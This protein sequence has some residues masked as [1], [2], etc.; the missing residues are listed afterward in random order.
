LQEKHRDFEY[1]AVLPTSLYGYARVLQTG[2][3]EPVQIG[4]A[5]VCTISSAFS[6]CRLCSAGDF[7]DFDERVDARSRGDSFPI[8]YGANTWQPTRISPAGWIRLTDR[9]TR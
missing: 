2:G 7:N 6:A 8:V 1:V 5:P 3:A 4:A 9:D